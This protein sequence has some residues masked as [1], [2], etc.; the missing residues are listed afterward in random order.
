MTAGMGM[1]AAE[2]RHALSVARSYR[3]GVVVI[4]RDVGVAR[5]ACH[6]PIIRAGASPDLAAY[7][8][9]AGLTVEEAIAYEECHACRWR[10]MRESD[11]A[12]GGE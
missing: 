9:A 10:M 5:C 2:K 3:G 12:G 1:Y 7:G 4:T 8:R 11:G 6:A